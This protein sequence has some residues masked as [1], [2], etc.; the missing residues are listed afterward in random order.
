MNEK[1]PTKR[2]GRRAFK[3]KMTSKIKPLRQKNKLVLFEE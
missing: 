1:Q 2:P 3:A